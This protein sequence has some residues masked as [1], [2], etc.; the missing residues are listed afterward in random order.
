MKNFILKLR[1]FT[2]HSLSLKDHLKNQLQEEQRFLKEKSGVQIE[3]MSKE[4]NK[5]EGELHR[6]RSYKVIII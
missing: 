4:N 5:C 6:F 2:T 1:K 3:M